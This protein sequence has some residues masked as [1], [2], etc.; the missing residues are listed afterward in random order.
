MNGYIQFSFIGGSEAKG[1]FVQATQDE[2]SVLFR[3]NQQAAVEVLRDEL[4]RRISSETSKS[5]QTSSMDELEKL[6]VLRDKGVVSEEEFQ[7]KK[8]MLLGF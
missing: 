5:L 7:Q 6:A 3:A 1:G 8:K 4:Q 2:N